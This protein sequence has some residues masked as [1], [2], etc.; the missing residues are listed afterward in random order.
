M[1][2][3][4]SGIQFSAQITVTSSPSQERVEHCE[5]MRSRA[6]KI[7]PHRLRQSNPTGKSL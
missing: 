7:R 4:I 1:S 5:L 2:E 6:S 3:A